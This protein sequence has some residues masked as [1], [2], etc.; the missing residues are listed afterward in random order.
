MIDVHARTN[1]GAELGGVIGELLGEILSE[2]VIESRIVFDE[3]GVQQLAA[4][5]T[6]LQDDGLEHRAPGVQSGAH[7]R[8]AR[9]DDYDVVIVGSPHD[10]KM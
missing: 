4:W 3:L 9:S 6:L 5:K 1:L 7:P 10:D 8:G 2:D